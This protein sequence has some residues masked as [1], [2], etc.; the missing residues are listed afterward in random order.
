MA[1]KLVNKQVV[2]SYSIVVLSQSNQKILIAEN[3]FW[4]LLFK[5]CFS[6]WRENMFCHGQADCR[7]E[8]WETLGSV[9]YGFSVC[10]CIIDDH[11]FSLD[12]TIWQKKKK[13]DRL[14]G[15]I[16]NWI[17]SLFDNQLINCK[18]YI[19]DEYLPLKHSPNIAFWQITALF[20]EFIQC[21]SGL[22][23]IHMISVLCK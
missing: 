15:S 4:C 23:G 8:W 5:Y 21:G 17:D 16:L 6:S 14:F 7:T 20:V 3:F 9:C 13:N 11:N 10:F 18:L 2:V 19:S 22:I 12:T 1:I